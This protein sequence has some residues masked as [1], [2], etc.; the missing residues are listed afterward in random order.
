MCLRLL[1]RGL[2]L[3]DIEDLSCIPSSTV[4]LCFHQ[5]ISKFSEVMRPLHIKLPVGNELKEV[6]DCYNRMGFPGVIG[7]VDSTHLKWKRCPVELTNLNSSK[8]GGPVLRWQCVVTHA[9]KI[10]S[11]SG[12]YYG[13]S[14][15]IIISRF[16][17]FLQKLSAREIYDDVVYNVFVDNI[18]QQQYKGVHLLCDGGYNKESY[19]IDPVAF[20]TNKSEVYWSEWLESIRKDV[21]C[22]FGILKCRFRI[23]DH[24]FELQSKEDIDYVFVTCCILHN[25]LLSMDGLDVFEWENN[26]N[27]A[28]LNDDEIFVDIEQS[29][30]ELNEI[31]LHDD[32]N[33]VEVQDQV[34]VENFEYNDPSP[35]LE[36]NCSHSTTSS[37]TTITVTDNVRSCF[38]YHGKR[39]LL[40]KHFAIAYNKGRVQ[41][42]L[43]FSQ[44]KKNKYPVQVP[45][46]VP[47]VLSITTT[48]ED[49]GLVSGTENM[50]V[51]TSESFLYRAVS[52]L[53]SINSNLSIGLGL[54]TNKKLIGGTHVAYYKGEFIDKTEMLKRTNILHQ[55]G[56]MIGISNHGCGKIMDCYA[57]A[58]RGECLASLANSPTG[59]KYSDSSSDKVPKSNCDIRINLRVNPTTVRLVVKTKMVVEANEELLVAYGNGYRYP[60]SA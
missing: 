33:A 35:T 40:M 37:T 26:V 23:L 22:T 10:I 13:V 53:K 9:R 17:D 14:N 58:T 6:M 59:C 44:V 56:Y 52:K 60:T 24:S 57:A 18:I 5:F 47:R 7:S 12:P 32:E 51:P 54:F 43:N 38:S 8:E 45:D 19:L 49:R 42:P 41:W 21:E 27:W 55:G 31:V 25:M 11:I 46:V 2:T 50:I 34:E 39:N 29:T 36:Q 48:N 15:D 4:W 16:D 30:D 28:E 1:G 3:D 20:R